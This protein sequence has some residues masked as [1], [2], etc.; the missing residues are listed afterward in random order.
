MGTIPGFI[1]DGYEWQTCKL[2]FIISLLQS[3]R[4]NINAKTFCLFFSNIHI[5][6]ETIKK[7]DGVDT[8]AW[9][10]SILLQTE[11]LLFSV[12]SAELKR[13]VDYW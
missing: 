4:S 6:K 1:T 10:G 7:A 3:Y 9:K 13:K 5:N 2:I 12:G 11:S 8:D